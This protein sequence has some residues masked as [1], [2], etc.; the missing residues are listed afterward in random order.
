MRWLLEAG[1]SFQDGGYVPAG[2]PVP[3]TLHGPELVVSLGNQMAMMRVLSRLGG[4]VGG[5]AGGFKNYGQ[6]SI[7]DDGGSDS[8]LL[9]SMVRALN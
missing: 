5:I 4:A 2:A 8:R 7:V 9:K 1:Q 6:V 3:A